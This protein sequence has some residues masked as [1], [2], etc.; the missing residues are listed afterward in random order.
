MI[1]T[2][3]EAVSGGAAHVTVVDVLNGPGV[4]VGSS[5]T[6]APPEYSAAMV[7]VLPGTNPGLSMRCLIYPP[8]S[9]AVLYSGGSADPSK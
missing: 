2:L 8:A 9:T 3:G 5:G 4:S 1:V 7:T 6:K